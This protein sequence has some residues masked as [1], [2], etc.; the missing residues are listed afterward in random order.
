MKKAV[1]VTLLASTLG[2]GAAAVHAES[3]D[4][5]KRGHGYSK[6]EGGKHHGKRGGR[7]GGGKHMMKRMAK[8]LELTE[9][10]QTEL[11]TLREAQKEQYKALR[12]EMKS[13]REKMKALD[14]TSA[15]YDSQV[16][17]IADEK[18]N[19]ERKRFIQKSAARQSFMN[20][21]TEEQRTKL[22]TMKE[23][24]KSRHGKRDSE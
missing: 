22:K 10:Q 6:H 19:F 5:S 15:D 1:L 7:H 4:S 17:A 12:E 14:T 9:A 16:A 24:R 11:K 23:E 13:L 3:G 18:A 2:L 20:V 21:L 8:K